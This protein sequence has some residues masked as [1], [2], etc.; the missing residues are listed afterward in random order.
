MKRLKQASRVAVIPVA[1]C[2]LMGAGCPNGSLLDQLSG[3]I[4]QLPVDQQQLLNLV[5][6]FFSGAAQ[7][8]QSQ[9]LSDPNLA[10]EDVPPAF[11]ED[12]SLY[13]A[14]PDDME[15]P[16]DPVFSAVG[17]P[18]GSAPPLHGRLVGRFWN[19]QPESDSGSSPGIFRGQWFDASG[20]LAGYIRGRY[21][22]AP[23]DELPEGLAAGGVFR[24]RYVDLDGRFQGY[25]FGRYGRDEGDEQGMF[26]G[27]WVGRDGQELGELRGRWIDE[28]QVNG[29]RFGGRWAAFDV[30]NESDELPLDDPNAQA[31]R[32]SGSDDL[33]AEPGEIEAFIEQTADPNDLSDENFPLDEV[34]DPELE[35]PERMP[36]VDLS[37]PHGV[38][39]GVWESFDPNDSDVPNPNADGVMY[40]RWRDVNGG[41]TGRIVGL[42]AYDVPLPDSAASDPNA[43]AHDAADGVHGRF[44]AHIIDDSGELLGSVHGRF[45][46]SPRGL[47]VFR[48]E[49]FDL[50]GKRVGA[51]RGR[52]LGDEGDGH[53]VGIWNA[54]GVE[55]S[56][57]GPDVPPPGSDGPHDSDGFDD[58]D[59]PQSDGHGGSNG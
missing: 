56:P 25:I 19:D 39:R 1:A 53:F 20:R 12:P 32:D 46:R 43:A 24:G 15:F 9:L 54:P 16:E 18:P 2:L 29:G 3:L 52:W 35:N 42:W 22:P 33:S 21:A 6:Q 36:C 4:S 37:G 11:G 10:P 26:A 51:M 38:L 30:C 5:N 23:A 31:A 47:G 28:P 58:S 48:G 40:G 59:N 14:S 34:E 49:M 8:D 50:S 27:R 13:E 55:D 17:P 7:Q 45:G 41:Y 44:F 57:G